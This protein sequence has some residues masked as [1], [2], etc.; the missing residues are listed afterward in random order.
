MT[1]YALNRLTI[2]LK[3]FVELEM[4]KCQLTYYG[5]DKYSG[6][7]RFH[8]E[9]DGQSFLM[10]ERTGKASCMG[11]C[12]FKEA[13]ITQIAALL[14]HCSNAEA[15]Q[16][17]QEQKEKY[18]PRQLKAR[19]KGKE[20][21]SPTWNWRP[22]LMPFPDDWIKLLALQR[23]IPELGIQR[24]IDLEL[25]WY[26][27]ERRWRSGLP[28]GKGDKG[29][30]PHKCHYKSIPASWVIADRTREQAIRRRMDGQRW[31]GKAKSK[32]LPGCS[33]KTEIGLFEALAHDGDI[34]VVE[35]GPDLLAALAYFPTCGVICMPS[36]VSD[37]SPKAKRE[38]RKRNVVII[39]H[40]DE[41]GRKALQRW[42]RGLPQVEELDYG[43]KDFNEFLTLTSC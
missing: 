2:S 21:S 20:E 4:P 29:L 39:P 30:H 28:Q 14:W 40:A 18:G 17:I 7:C 33:G 32:L 12:G 22:C 5:K 26:L 10:D 41:A 31:D 27:P 35:G 43:A 15:A 37:F 42:A 6:N 19:N 1:I 25:L 13:D 24:A 23:G 36:S 38:L 3:K 9:V 34:M 11:K 16:R 8:Q